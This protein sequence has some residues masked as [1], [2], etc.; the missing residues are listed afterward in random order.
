MSNTDKPKDH[1]RKHFRAH[2]VIGAAQI[3]VRAT[4]EVMTLTENIHLGV[5]A[6]A[7][8]TPTSRLNWIHKGTK[9]IYAGI[10]IPPNAAAA[11]LK[12]I[13]K[14]FGQQISNQESQ[15]RKQTL[16]AMNGILGDQLA[17]NHNPLTT[18]FTVVTPNK[19]NHR[20]HVIFLH[21]LCMDDSSWQQQ[22]QLKKLESLPVQI[23]YV[24]YN[25]GL[26]IE[27]NALL[28]F[29]HLSKN[30]QFDNTY[31]LIGH[32]MGGLIAHQA[33]HIAATKQSSLIDSVKNLITVGT[34]HHGAPLAKLG[35]W[36]EQQLQLNTFTLPFTYLTSQRSA[37]IK[38][39]QH[40]F[41]EQLNQPNLNIY[42]IAGELN[43]SIKPVKEQLGDGLVTES[44]ALGLANAKEAQVFTNVSHLGLLSDDRVWEKF[45]VVLSG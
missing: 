10:K 4:N 3:A 38:D 43:S 28:L 5:L 12:P 13:A 19:N 24:R 39:L 29:E 17:A 32:S 20:H 33:L 30:H 23:S 8:I 16:A 35:H 31:S 40:G 45:Q 14:K 44:S 41:P 11:L 37:G 36:L 22:V 2:D 1:W 7:G 42:C 26:P 15:A 9:L 18:Q 34:P 25:S 21:G 6:T 27:E